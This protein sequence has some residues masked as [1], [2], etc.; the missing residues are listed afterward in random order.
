MNSYNILTDRESKVR[1]Y[2]SYALK[3]Y[4]DIA[5]SVIIMYQPRVHNKSAA[6]NTSLGNTII[7]IELI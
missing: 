1:I 6:Y 7:T 3:N 4:H 5:A 2:T